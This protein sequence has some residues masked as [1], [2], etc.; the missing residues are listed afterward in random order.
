LFSPL[1]YGGRLGKVFPRILAIACTEE[2]GEGLAVAL[3]PG[4]RCGGVNNIYQWI[5]W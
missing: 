3:F 1:I 4:V 2:R 5:E